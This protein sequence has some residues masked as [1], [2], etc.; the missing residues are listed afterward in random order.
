MRR[1]LAALSV[2]CFLGLG[3]PASAQAAGSD[4][5]AVVVRSALRT[6]QCSMFGELEICSSRRLHA[7][8]RTLPDGRVLV[9]YIATSTYTTTD[10]SGSVETNSDRFMYQDAYTREGAH[11]IDRHFFSASVKWRT[12]Q[13]SCRET[14]RF[15]EVNYR[16]VFTTG[17]F[18]CR[19]L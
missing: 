13:V 9:T 17:K 15:G 14:L 7:T 6:S 2:A 12:S 8:Q 19:L 10:A 4:R 5:G 16:Q 18:S 11:G 1:I 3:L